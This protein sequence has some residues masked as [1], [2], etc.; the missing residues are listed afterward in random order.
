MHLYIEIQN[1]TGSERILTT[2]NHVE[3]FLTESGHVR[4]SI[5]SRSILPSFD[6][7]F[8]LFLMSSSGVLIIPRDAQPS[9]RRA[10]TMENMARFAA[11][12]SLAGWDFARGEL[13]FSFNHLALFSLFNLHDHHFTNNT[14][15]FTASD[16]CK[17]ILAVLLVS[18][19]LF[20]SRPASSLPFPPVPLSLDALHLLEY[21][22]NILAWLLSCWSGTASTTSSA[23]ST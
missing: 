10:V 6:L 12:P 5:L 2:C 18:C 16:I 14:M 19:S 8:S 11:P 22:S 3:S 1:Q 4:Q 9:W 13:S 21:R 17:I 15:P 23:R 20:E 7:C